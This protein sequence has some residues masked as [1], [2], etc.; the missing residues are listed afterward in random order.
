M[1]GCT[2]SLAFAFSSLLSIMNRDG[3]WIVHGDKVFSLKA[4]I[5]SQ[6]WPTDAIIVDLWADNKLNLFIYGKSA[7][8]LYRELDAAH[9]RCYR[10]LI[11]I[12]LHLIFHLFNKVFNEIAKDRANNA[13]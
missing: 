5:C 2:F 7:N 1:S 9:W 12:E 4:Q 13:T 8:G 11:V 10:L 3:T 6:N